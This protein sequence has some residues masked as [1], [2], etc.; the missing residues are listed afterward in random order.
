MLNWRTKMPDDKYNSRIDK[1]TIHT[2]SK[3]SS[4]V[5]PFDVLRSTAGRE[6]IKRHA[7]M[8]INSNSNETVRS[9]GNDIKLK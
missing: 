8:T 3:G 2:T 7:A 6:L 4:Y 9:S 1:P 5:T